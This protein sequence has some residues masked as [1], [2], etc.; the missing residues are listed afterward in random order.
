[1]SWEAIFL[2]PNTMLGEKVL[3]YCKFIFFYFCVVCQ[4]CIKI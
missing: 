4:R 3:D 1:M 2:A